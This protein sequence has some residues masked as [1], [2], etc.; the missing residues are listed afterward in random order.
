MPA[1]VGQ[2]GQVVIEKALRDALGIE[3]GYVAVQRMMGDHIELYFYPPEH[4]DSLLGALKGK[5]QIPKEE[6]E[7]A[8]IRQR[9]WEIASVRDWIEQEISTNKDNK[10]Q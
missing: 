1:I 3:P 2:K 6:M 5:V 4:N 9:A 8:D 7:W 10:D